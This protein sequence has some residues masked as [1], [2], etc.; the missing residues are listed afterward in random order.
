M[1]M[2]KRSHLLLAA[3]LIRGT[4]DCARMSLTP[5]TLESPAIC[6]GAR[7]APTRVL[8]RADCSGKTI[9]TIVGAGRG[10]RKSFRG[11]LNGVV[12][13]RAPDPRSRGRARA[14]SPVRWRLL[15][16]RRPGRGPRPG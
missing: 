8:A 2:G 10:G 16:L 7:L 3:A 15:L 4:R 1:A 5:T 14:R 9:I 11:P 12:R 6:L 13:D